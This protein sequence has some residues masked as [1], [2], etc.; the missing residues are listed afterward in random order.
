[1]LYTILLCV[2]SLET[3]MAHTTVL[4]ITRLA[5]QPCLKKGMVIGRPSF[6]K[7]SLGYCHYISPLS[8][9][10]TVIPSIPALKAGFHYICHMLT[11]NWGRQ[12]SVIRHPTSGMRS[13]NLYGC[14]HL[15]H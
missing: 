11:P 7:R 8:Y 1:M 6:T 9:T 2:L 4:S 3:A 5:G 13:K 10:G 15:F 14:A 12:P